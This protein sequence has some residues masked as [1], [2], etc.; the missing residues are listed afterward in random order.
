MYIREKIT[1]DDTLI[2]KL[3]RFISKIINYK[4]IKINSVC[5]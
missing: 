3:L 4:L 5:S 2:I 1:A